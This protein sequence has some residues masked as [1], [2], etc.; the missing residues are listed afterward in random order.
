MQISFTM[1]IFYCSGPSLGGKIFSGGG[2]ASGV[3]SAPCGRKPVTKVSA[4]KDRGESYMIV[5]P[6][7]I[8]YL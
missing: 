6:L 1:L 2:V 3:S 7:L 8:R 5:K 4:L